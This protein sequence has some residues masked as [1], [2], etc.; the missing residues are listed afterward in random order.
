MNK[1]K[2]PKYTLKEELINSIS[3]GI[4]ACLAIAALVLLIIK[5]KN[6]L[7]TVCVSIYASIMIILFT[8]S[9][10]YHA[11]SPNLKGKKVLRVID[12][13]NVLLM[14]FGTYLP[15]SLLGIKNTL[16]WTIFAITLT[17]TIISI[18]LT[19]INVDKFQIPEVILTLIIGWSSLIGLK[20][21][22]ANTTF[23][24]FILLLIGGIIYSIG[25]IL[26]AIGSKKKYIH[27]VFHFFV[28]AGSITHFFMIYLYLI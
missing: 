27:S 26:Y 8:I 18:T 4:A 14:V 2:I 19:A 24:A 13:C 25:A 23:N 15:V 1:I 17:I 20:A 22:I 3:H 12:H 21:L 5:S 7:S 6:A 16:G 28:I 10:I 9:S 11:L